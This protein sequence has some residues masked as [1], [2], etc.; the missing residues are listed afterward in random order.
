MSWT[1]EDQEKY[2]K[3]VKELLER[4][5]QRKVEE[6]LRKDGWK[7]I[8]KSWRKEEAGNENSKKYW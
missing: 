1:K 2:N 8:N 7:L 4:H 3:Y 5:R 6:K